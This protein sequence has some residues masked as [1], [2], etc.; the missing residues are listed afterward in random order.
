MKPLVQVF[1]STDGQGWA[2]VCRRCDQ[3]G[4]D[5]TWSSTLGR[6]IEHA[7]NHDTA[8]FRPPKGK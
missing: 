6:G 8:G 2:Y 7:A 1:Q 3:G 5:R 4:W